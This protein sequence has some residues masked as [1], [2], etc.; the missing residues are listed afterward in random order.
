VE[1]LANTTLAF[2]GGAINGTSQYFPQLIVNSRRLTIGSGSPQ[3]DF[4]RAGC[5]RG[6]KS[7]TIEGRVPR[8]FSRELT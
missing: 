5:R 2:S 8:R 6:R 3:K 7:H 1:K 4:Q